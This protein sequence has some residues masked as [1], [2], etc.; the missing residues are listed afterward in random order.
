LIDQRQS[1]LSCSEHDK[2]SSSNDNVSTIDMPWRNF[3]N[4]EFGTKYPYFWRYLN[5]LT[6]QCRIGGRKLASQKTS[7]IHSTVSTEH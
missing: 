1:S 2:L 4:Q 6:M 7:S 5:F 3:L